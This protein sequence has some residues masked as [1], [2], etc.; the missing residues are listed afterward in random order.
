VKVFPLELFDLAVH[1][2]VYEL[3]EF[4]LQILRANTVAE[5]IESFLPTVRKLNYHQLN[6]VYA[7][8]IAINLVKLM[9]LKFPFH[10]AGKMV[11]SETFRK[12]SELH[13]EYPYEYWFCDE[14]EEDEEIEDIL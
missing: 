2:E 5:S 6:T 13:G 1:F 10:K 11:L 4:C 14:E 3:E 8:L 7:E 12:L 9:E